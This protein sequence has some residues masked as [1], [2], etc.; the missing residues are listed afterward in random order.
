MAEGIK[1]LD[2]LECLK[3]DKIKRFSQ[4]KALVEKELATA[5][6][7]YF[8]AKE[9]LERN[10]YKWATIQAYYSMFHA[11]RSLLYNKDYREKSHYCLIVA[12]KALY[13]ETGELSARF[14]EGLQ[15]SKNLREDADYYD[16]WSNIGASEMINLAREFLDSVEAILKKKA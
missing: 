9:S 13:V 5:E 16:E 15:K 7:D 3:K 2:F 1:N 4:G 12:L 8:E 11:A 6:K 14:V 10:K